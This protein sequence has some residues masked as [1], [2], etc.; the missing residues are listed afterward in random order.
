MV[1]GADHHHFIAVRFVAGNWRWRHAIYLYYFLTMQ[2]RVK[3]LEAILSLS[4]TM[5]LVYFL[6][7]KNDILLYGVLALLI[8]TLAFKAL[9]GKLAAGWL[10]VTHALGRFY[11]TIILGVLYYFILT[12]IA[13]I[14][15]QF[16]RKKQP[17]ISNLDDRD[18]PYGP[19]D[20]D[21]IF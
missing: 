19:A 9:S 12:P 5:L 16:N 15:R 2:N 11:T 14:F 6:F 10:L 18:H 13:F 1:A 4:V 7:W 21:Q 8:F 3:H 17:E 20:F